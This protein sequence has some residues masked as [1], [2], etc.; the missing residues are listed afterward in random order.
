MTNQSTPGGATPESAEAA[1]VEEATA[2][3]APAPG[4]AD[5][6][7]LL[8]QERDGAREE[9]QQNHDRFLREAAELQ[10]LRKRAVE[11]EEKARKF[12]VD[13]F[14]SDLLNVKDSLEMGLTAAASEPT[15]DSLQEGMEATLR[16]LEQAFEKA[17]LTVI[18]PSD[19]PF[20]PRQHEAM[21]MQEVPGL[22][23]EK[24]LAVIQKGYLLH[25]RVLR[26][27]R[28]MVGKPAPAPASDAP[29]PDAEG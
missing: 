3:G 22:T 27:A 6:L 9:A 11:R 25:D 19:E 2:G 23:E 13:R 4:S 14:A 8:R 29:T 17:N 1:G 15:V 16:Q 7:E 10:N 24:V 21:A 5:E 28:V 12:A 26:P 18:D 20:D